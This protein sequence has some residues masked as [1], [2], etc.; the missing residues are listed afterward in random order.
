ML[1]EQSQP[2]LPFGLV[3][4]DGRLSLRESTLRRA[5]F[6]GAKGDH[7]SRNARAFGSV[8]CWTEFGEFGDDLEPFAGS[9]LALRGG[10]QLR[11]ED[12]GPLLGDD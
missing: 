5:H 11:L 12:F 8:K 7:F 1:D 6:R 4:A 3:P 9:Q 10:G 2:Q